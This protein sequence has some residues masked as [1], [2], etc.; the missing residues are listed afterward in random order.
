[1]KII[2]YISIIILFF[3]IISC[4]PRPGT[5]TDEDADAPLSELGRLNS[6]IAV[7][8]INDSLYRMRSLAYLDRNDINSALGDINKALQ[9]NGRSVDNLITLSDIYLAMGQA[10]KVENSLLKAMEIDENHPALLFKVARFHLIMKDYPTTYAYI[11]KLLGIESYYPQA[12]F[13]RALALLEDRDTVK[14]VEDLQ[15]VVAQDSEHADAY[16]LLASLYRDSDAAMAIAYYSNALEL[17]PGSMQLWYELALL[18]QQQGNTDDALAAYRKIPADDALL[19]MAM[20]NIGYIYMM[21]ENRY[22]SAQHYFTASIACD[23]GFVNAWYNRGLAYELNG[24]LQEARNDYR[25]VLKLEANYTRA[26]EALNRLDE[27][28]LQEAR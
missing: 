22:D 24:E 4:A 3:G 27:K 28:I 18:Y 12:Y 15:K 2:K 11:D 16:A 10:G 9:L 5:N 14:A 20:H 8:S 26:V 23:S 21:N 7:D 13:L 25:I 6:L 17:R 1:M 19:P